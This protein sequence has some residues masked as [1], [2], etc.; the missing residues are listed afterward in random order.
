MFFQPIKFGEKERN[1]TDPVRWI[2]NPIIDG[3]TKLPGFN[4]DF[5]GAAP[6]AGA[7]EVGNPPLQFG[8]RAYMNYDEGWAP[9]EK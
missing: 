2:K 6:D 1:V 4:D 3:G 8:R 5:K 9:W 7:F